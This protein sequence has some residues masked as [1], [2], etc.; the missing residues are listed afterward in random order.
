V[1]E[2]TRTVLTLFVAVATAFSI[3]ASHTAV[4]DGVA[5]DARLPLTPA[6]VTRELGWLL[7]DCGVGLACA[8]CS[9]R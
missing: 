9:G 1:K 8:A 3:E 5:P 4:V 2:G 7:Y 6:V